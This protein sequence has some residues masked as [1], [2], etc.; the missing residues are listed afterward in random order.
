MIKKISKYDV[1]TWVQGAI[2][3]TFSGAFGG[4][5]A[6]MS[7]WLNDTHHDFGGMQ[8]LKTALFPTAVS[9]GIGLAL[10]LKQSPFPPRIE[11]SM[12]VD[13]GTGLERDAAIV[14]AETKIHVKEE[15]PREG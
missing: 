12:E 14:I 6:A 15:P 2:A 4:I 5:A 9:A 11:V 1:P 13:T 8:L 7:V 10:Y 3:A